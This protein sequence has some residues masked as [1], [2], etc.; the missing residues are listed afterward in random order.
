MLNPLDAIRTAFTHAHILHSMMA[1]YIFYFPSH[2]MQHNP[3]CVVLLSS[4][5]M[6]VRCR[7]AM[8]GHLKAP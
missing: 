4:K 2:A 6:H 1:T 7:L 8:A 5:T 3:A